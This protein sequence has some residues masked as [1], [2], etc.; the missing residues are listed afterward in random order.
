[1]N[2]PPQVF[3]LSD[4]MS[5]WDCVR[6]HSDMSLLILL[7]DFYMEK[8]DKD[9]L[10]SQSHHHFKSDSNVLIHFDTMCFLKPTF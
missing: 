8:K 2:N 3:S 6:F 7:Q 1:M 10:I 5:I 9:F 4:G